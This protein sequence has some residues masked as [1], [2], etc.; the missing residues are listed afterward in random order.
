MATASVES[1]NGITDISK[2]LVEIK[3]EIEY[4]TDY[5]VLDSKYRELLE[6]G[7]TPISKFKFN[8]VNSRILQVGT[9]NSNADIEDVVEMKLTSI[10]APFGI[11]RYDGS[12][13]YMRLSAIIDQ[14][15]GQSYIMSASMKAHWILRNAE[16]RFAAGKR[17]EFNIE[18][19]SD[20]VFKFDIP[21]RR[22]DDI[23]VRF[24]SPVYPVT[25]YHDRDT[26]I[27]TGYGITTTIQ[28]TYNHSFDIGTKSWITASGFRTNAAV[29]DKP[30]IDRVN[31]DV[32]ILATITG[33]NTMAL[34]LDTTTVTPLI[35]MQFNVFFED[36]RIKLP[37]EVTYKVAPLKPDRS[38]V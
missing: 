22:L 9:V 18:E 21:I 16:Y 4:R 26:A 10:V 15:S 33:V 17:Y 27:V 25:Y 19:F 38:N 32:E 37:I 1:I 30:I 13:S 6:S 2:L 24:G 23:T 36:R 11:E 28:T 29:A 12:L 7:D 3:P 34:T 31:N 20:G 5:I 8:L 14:I 35:G